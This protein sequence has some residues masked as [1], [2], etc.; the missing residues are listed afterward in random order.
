MAFTKQGII[1]ELGNG[2]GGGGLLVVL[3]WSGQF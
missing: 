2:V 1:I 3:P